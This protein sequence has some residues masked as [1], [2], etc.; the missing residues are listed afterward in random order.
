MNLNGKHTVSSL[1][2]YLLK[3]KALEM[4]PDKSVTLRPSAFRGGNVVEQH[5]S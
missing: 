2:K 5:G 1:S 4:P 3:W